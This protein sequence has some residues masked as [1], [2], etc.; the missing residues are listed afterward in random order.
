MEWISVKD[1]LPELYDFVL[2]LADN[3]GTNEPK[4]IAISRLKMCGW[5]FLHTNDMWTHGVY[6]DITYNIDL[7]DITHWMHLPS[8][9]PKEE[10]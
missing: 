8:P 3:P 5:E 2:V 1:R 10:I 7:D 4:P 9:P 6:M